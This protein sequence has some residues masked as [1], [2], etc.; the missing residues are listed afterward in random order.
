MQG[1]E[2]VKQQGEDRSDQQGIGNDNKTHSLVRRQRI[3]A[4]RPF[5]PAQQSISNYTSLI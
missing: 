2:Q 1:K 5:N 3:E 4:R